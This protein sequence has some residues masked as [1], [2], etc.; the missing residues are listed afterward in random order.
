VICVRGTIENLKPGRLTDG[1][2]SNVWGWVLEPNSSAVPVKLGNQGRVVRRAPVDV[3]RPDIAAA[4]QSSPSQYVAWLDGDDHWTS[5]Y[6]LQKQ[7]HYLD[8]RP[9]CAMCVHNVTILYEC[10]Q[11]ISTNPV[12]MGTE[13]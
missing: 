10:C 2:E 1:H 4:S 6:K 13:L 3:C 12:V 9:E 8:A 7:A 11:T 5:P